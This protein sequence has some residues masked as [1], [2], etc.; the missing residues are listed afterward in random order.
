MARKK[1]MIDVERRRKDAE[2][3][4]YALTLV[5]DLFIKP[6]DGKGGTRRYQ[7]DVQLRTAHD[8]LAKAVRSAI[9]EADRM[10]RAI[11]RTERNRDYSLEWARANGGAS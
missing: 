7:Y 4:F 11:S 1:E 3:T 10:N 8:R 6:W 5:D 2:G 9:R